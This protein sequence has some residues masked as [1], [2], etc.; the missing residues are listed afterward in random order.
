MSKMNYE[1]PKT[2]NSFGENRFN[3]KLDDICKKGEKEFSR[4]YN[5]RQKRTHIN[6]AEM[7]ETHCKCGSQHIVATI[8]SG[9]HAYRW[10]CGTCQAF[11]KWSSNPLSEN[12]LEEP[13]PVQGK[14]KL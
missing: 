2:R 12:I 10:R 9:P 5:A 7:V 1:N 11:I 4:Q 14:H 8:G 13:K 3:A 6:E